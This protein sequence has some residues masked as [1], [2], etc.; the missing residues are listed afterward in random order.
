MV[1]CEVV[2]ETVISGWFWKGGLLLRNGKWKSL[3][4]LCTENASNVTNTTFRC[5]LVVTV[6]NVNFGCV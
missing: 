1:W 2:M 5:N 4:D 3:V 6:G